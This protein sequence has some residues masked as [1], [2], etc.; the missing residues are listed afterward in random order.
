[1]FSPSLLSHLDNGIGSL[2][3]LRNSHPIEVPVKDPNEINQVSLFRALK[4]HELIVYQIFD[5]ISYSKGSCVIRM[6]AKFLGEETFL[7]GVQ[8]YI[9]RHA[10]GNTVVSLSFR[11]PRNCLKLQ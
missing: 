4:S 6:L 3:S 10:Y 1:M 5:A 7:K 8:L 2:D 11:A 9:K